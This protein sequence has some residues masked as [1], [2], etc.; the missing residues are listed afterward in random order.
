MTKNVETVPF[1]QVFLCCWKPSNQR[2]VVYSRLGTP[3]FSR[4]SILW[5]YGTRSSGELEELIH[6]Y[7]HCKVIKIAWNACVS[8][9]GGPS[10]MLQALLPFPFNVWAATRWLTAMRPN[11]SLSI[12]SSRL[13]PQTLAW[14][15]EPKTIPPNVA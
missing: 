13:E 12:H 5:R 6:A 9:C 2:A 1:A 14:T 8:S 10:S 11:H 4:V 7:E 15:S 3:F